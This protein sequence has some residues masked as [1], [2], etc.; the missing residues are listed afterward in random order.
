MMMIYFSDSGGGFVMKEPP[1]AWSVDVVLIVFLKSSTCWIRIPLFTTCSSSHL[2]DIF[3]IDPYYYVRVSSSY[4]RISVMNL[5][6]PQR[7]PVYFCWSWICL[8]SLKVA[9]SKLW[10]KEEEISPTKILII[11]PSPKMIIRRIKIKACI[12]DLGLLCTSSSMWVTYTSKTLH[13]N[14]ILTTSMLL[15]LLLRNTQHCSIPSQ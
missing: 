3:S 14:Q 13:N 12:P 4:T 1:V 7:P 2:Q 15:P 10:T 11:P 8:A 9:H 6:D 5:Q